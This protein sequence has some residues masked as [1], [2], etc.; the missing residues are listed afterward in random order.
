MNQSKLIKH[1]TLMLL[2]LENEHQPYSRLVL[3]FLL[4]FIR[5][6]VGTNKNYVS[7]CSEYSYTPLSR[8]VPFKTTFASSCMYCPTYHATGQ[9]CLTSTPE[10][11][12]LICPS[13]R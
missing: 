12:F 3:D 1:A 4:M 7:R 5:P 13:L 8:Q 11:C 10:L 9:V 6:N 2:A